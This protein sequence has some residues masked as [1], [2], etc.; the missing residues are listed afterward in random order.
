MRPARVLDDLLYRF[1]IALGLHL[2]TATCRKRSA[3]AR[4]QD[5]ITHFRRFDF[6][7]ASGSVAITFALAAMALVTVVG[8]AI[9]YS[10]ATQ[11]RARLQAVTD[12][13][14]LNMVRQAASLSDTN[15]RAAIQNQLN[16][17]L[18][19]VTITI[20]SMT[21]GASRTSLAL[22]TS[23]PST[24]SVMPAFTPG[25]LRVNASSQA[26]VGNDTFEIA[27]VVDNSGSMASSAGGASKM[28]SAKDAANGLID[29][30]MANA[31]AAARTKFSVVPFTLV[32]NIG[33]QYA[34]QTW[35]DTQAKSSIHWQNFEP[36]PAS[37][38]TVT[39]FNLFPAMGVSWGGCPE[40][41]P[42]NW[43]V[44]DAAPTSSIGDSLFV[45]MAAPDEPGN[46]GATTY[47]FGSTSWS[48]PNSYLNDNPG[49]CSSDITATSN[50][51]R[52][53]AKVC[54][55]TS[56]TG[57]NLSNG[58]GPNFNCTAQPLTR[59]TNSTTTLHT[60]INAMT[61]NGN[62]NLLE[63]FMWGW[64]T[65][66]PNLPF[67]DGRAYGTANNRKIIILLTDG[68][69]MWAAQNNHNKSSYSAFGYYTNNRLGTT[70]VDEASARA[71][72]DA[73]TLTACTNA[74]TQGIT[75][76]TVGFSVAGA[77]IDAA[78]LDLLKK[79]ATSDSTA[80]VANNSSQII[81]VFEEIARN[82]G[83][84]RLTN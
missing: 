22:V 83:S 80:F 52:A 1:A 48:Y 17:A 79:C 2:P 71:L 68:M 50:Y 45:P 53:Q 19:G 39:R 9:D 15:L 65:I 51:T 77:E 29:A 75:V 11:L 23:A 3:D 4:G 35:M 56:P 25:S 73:K 8:A 37:W 36:P 61:A 54:K 32:V 60:A 16:A 55:Y 13:A 40:T 70:A 63:G 21:V 58:R 20:D 69:N 34:T 46:G 7:N 14:A 41:R 78:G 82:L 33:S 24:N 38:G 5:V 10:R 66:S 31:S 67:P 72:I 26:A 47:T 62:T 18:P 59:L 64:R 30:M 76:Y 49:S 6:R 57:L 43:G 81:A 27:L 42:G 84:L 74:K 12:S 28:Q 44:T